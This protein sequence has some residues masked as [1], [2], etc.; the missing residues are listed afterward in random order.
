M[1]TFLRIL[2]APFTDP[3]TL[4]FVLSVVALCHRKRRALWLGLVILMLCLL[5]WPALP[6]G[7]H[8]RLIRQYGPVAGPTSGVSRIAVLSGGAFASDETVPVNGRARPT[9][10]YRFMEGIRIHRAVP[11]S[12]LVVSVCAAGGEAEAKRILG[13]LAEV[14]QVDPG[15]LTAVIGAENTRD[16][17]RL[18][19][20]HLGTDAFYLV[21]SDFHMPRAMMLFR[22]AGM[23]PIPAPA[24]ACGR[25]DGERPLRASTVWPSTVNMGVAERA[26][27]E[28]LGVAWARLTGGAVSTTTESDGKLP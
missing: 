1:P 23:H 20:E 14:T 21:T 16:E 15:Q 3:L 7:L 8:G 25:G 22:Q 4:V 12:R 17:A 11:G 5:G 9:F 19:R 18:M 24:G 13:D 10:L 28:Y 6:W 2:F 26:I 27:H